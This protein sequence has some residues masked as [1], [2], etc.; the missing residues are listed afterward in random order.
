[1]ASDCDNEETADIV[2]T[3]TADCDDKTKSV[4]SASELIP[5]HNAVSSLSQ[6]EAI[7][8]NSTNCFTQI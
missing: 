2:E 7:L 1:M 4:S 3:E 5:C 6:S 8:L